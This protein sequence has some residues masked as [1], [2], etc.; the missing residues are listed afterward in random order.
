MRYLGIWLVLIAT[1]V[2]CGREPRASRARTGDILPLVTLGG[3]S[4]YVDSAI[5]IDEALRRFRGDMPRAARLIRGQPSR[6]KLVRAFVRAV[7]ARDTAALRDMVLRRDEFAWLYYPASPLS[8]RPYELAPS[9]MW[10]QLQGE[11]NRGASRLLA[12]RAGQSLAY[13]GHTCAQPRIEGENRLYPYCGVRRV[14][15]AGDTLTERL[16]GL[17]IERGGSYKFVSYANQLD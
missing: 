10:F 3:R 11:S 17:I 14:S 6:E 8:R 4:G 15:A 13:V 7:E 2:G 9:L 5:P 16:F 1:L 12:E